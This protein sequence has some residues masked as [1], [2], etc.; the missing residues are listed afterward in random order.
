[1]TGQW[2]VAAHAADRIVLQSS[3]G[4]SEITVQVAP[5]P[6]TPPGLIAARVSALEGQ[7]LGLSLD[8]SRADRILGP[9]VAL[10]PGIGSVYRA[11]TNL[12]QAPDTPVAVALLASRVGTTAVL[13]TV[14]TPA[15]NPGEQATIFEQADDVINSI[16]VPTA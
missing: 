4:I 3:D 2:T 6:A 7:L 16:Q 11:T 10:V 8:T 14:I 9:G 1:M 13:A 5:A 12:P 15:N